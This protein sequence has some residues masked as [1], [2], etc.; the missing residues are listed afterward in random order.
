MSH[1]AVLAIFATAVVIAVISAFLTTSN[2]VE[3]RS[4]SVQAPPATTGLARPHA[5]LRPIRPDEN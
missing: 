1:R 5:P 2:D 3:T 4:A